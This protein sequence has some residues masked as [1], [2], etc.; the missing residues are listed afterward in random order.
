MPSLEALHR[1]DGV[2]LKLVVTNPPRPAGR[3]SNLRPTAV[4]EEAGRLGVPLTESEGVRTGAGS[5]ALRTLHPDVIL[6][7]AY[8]ELLTPAVLGLPPLGCVNVHLS[9]LPRWRGAAPVQRAILAGDSVTGVSVMRMDEGLDTGPVLAQVREPIGRDD[10][11]GSL[12]SRLAR[13]GATSVVD[14]LNG[15]ASGDVEARAQ[16]EAGALYARKL[17]PLER[18][19]DWGGTAGAIDRLVR[20]LSPEPGATTTFRGQPLK[21]LRVRQRVAEGVPSPG[22][23]LAQDL[24]VIG[25]GAGAVE[26]LEL[27]PSGRRRMSG[28]D[29]VRGARL[30]P[31]ER[32]G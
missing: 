26:L 32:F 14:V 20:A 3:G 23:I 18:V 27:A 21:I 24:P 7:V 11:A 9:L 4:A 15:L 19:I 8:G 2:D 16:D 13:I 5:D 17:A 30:L 22:R 29:W 10:D 1:A 31:D 28:A 6:V 12:G 25:T